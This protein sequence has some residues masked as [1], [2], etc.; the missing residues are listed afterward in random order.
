M[1]KPINQLHL[2]LEKELVKPNL[3]NGVEGVNLYT[4]T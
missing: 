4:N 1:W 2:A 3:F